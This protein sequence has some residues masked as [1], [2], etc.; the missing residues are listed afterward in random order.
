MP[1]PQREQLRA[2][3]G[4]GCGD[5]LQNG[6]FLPFQDGV[7]VVPGGDLVA[8]S[9]A[10][11]RVLAL[12]ARAAATDATVLITGESGTGKER[13]ARLLHAGSRRRAGAFV[14]VN[15]G[16]LPE[17]LLESELFGHKKGA[18]TGA[19]ADREGLFEAASGGTLF[20][21]EIGELPLSMQVKLLR[22]LQEHAV[23]PVGSTRDVPVDVR[24]V[25]ATNRDLEALVEG[26]GFRK[27]LFYRLRVV[28]LELPPLRARREDIL[29]LA[30]QLI[31]KTCRQNSCG[32]CA[33]SS[34]VL[35][36]L[37]AYPWPG[38][39]RELENAIER[40][41]VLA[42][43]QPRIELGDLPPELRAP[44]AASGAAPE[45]APQ[46]L[47]EV[48]R[49]HILATLERLRGN[50]AAT[51]RALGIGENTLWRKLKAFGVPGGR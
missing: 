30:R 28:P 49:R 2:D 3:A 50:R 27:D 19:A 18:F 20:L 26:G 21:D 39:V 41:V 10:M 51:A 22:A 46:T 33:L 47:A 9:E 15:C 23:R 7:L 16:A 36:A 12:A 13:V 32:P 45:P 24:V 31:A 40:A 14:G 35:D 48:E 34:E 44:V 6:G 38:N 43:G 4:A 29:P 5:C 1:A 8:R 11:Q 25:A 37:Y 42:E 17:P